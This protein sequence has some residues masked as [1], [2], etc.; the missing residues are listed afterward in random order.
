MKEK[1]KK[2]IYF[3][4]IIAVAFVISIPLLNK[5]L[6]VHFDDGIQHIARA[7]STSLAVENGE[8]TKVL[9]NLINGYGYSWDLFYGPLTTIIMVLINFIIKNFVITYKITLFVCLL[10]SGITMYMYVKRITENKNTACLSAVLYMTMPY[11]LNDMYIRN[12]LGEFA[13]FIFIPLVFFGLYNIF[14]KDK[15][16]YW[17]VIGTVR[18]YFNS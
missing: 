3:L 14:H 1:F 7:Y 4:L 9:S 6:D 10:L 8:S 17:F 2:I 11:H 16:D 18:T 13:S 5:E 15:K 12:S